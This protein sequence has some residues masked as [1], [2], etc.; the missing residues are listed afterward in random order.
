MASDSVGNQIGVAVLLEEFGE[1]NLGRMAEKKV[2]VNK[3]D[4]PRFEVLTVD[5]GPPTYDI[6]RFRIKFRKMTKNAK[7]I[8]TARTT[9]IFM[10]G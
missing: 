9:R 5:L 10:R 8:A 4:D 6:L 1:N 2:M 7:D 3:G